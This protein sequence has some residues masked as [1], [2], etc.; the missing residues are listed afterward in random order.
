MIPGA[1]VRTFENWIDVPL[2]VLTLAILFHAGE[3]PNSVKYL[4]AVAILLAWSEGLI[5][6]SKHPK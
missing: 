3:D 6:L 4:S 2:I 5:L 1:Y